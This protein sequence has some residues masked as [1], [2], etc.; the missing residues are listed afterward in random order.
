MRGRG[1]TRGGDY[2]GVGGGEGLKNGTGVT[3]G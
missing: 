3:Q 1:T 2:P